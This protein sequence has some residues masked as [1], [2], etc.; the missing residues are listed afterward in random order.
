[1]SGLSSEA[2]LSTRIPGALWRVLVL[3]VLSIA[4]NYVDRGNLSIAAPLL[5][6]ELGISASELGVL[7]SAFFWT[8]AAFQIVSGFTLYG[9]FAPGGFWNSLTGWMLVSIGSQWLRLAHHGVMWLLVGFIIN[10]VYSAW[11]MDV[12]ERNGT[13][14]GIFSGYKYIEPKDL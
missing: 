1:M 3:L 9:Q 14:S 7:L 13:I 5:K 10:H 6:D 8:Y 4:I 11:L 2:A 12:K